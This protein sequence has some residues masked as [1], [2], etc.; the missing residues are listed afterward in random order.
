[1]KKILV[2]SLLCS[3]L[4]AMPCSHAQEQGRAREKTNQRL[5]AGDHHTNLIHELGLSEETA[6]KFRNAIANNKTQLAPLWEQMQSIRDEIE[7]QLRAN[8]PD[9]ATAMAAVDKMAQVQ[10]QI[11]AIRIK[12]NKLIASLLT[13]EQLAKFKELR[14]QMQANRQNRLEQH[15]HDG[16]AGPKRQEGQHDR[17]RDQNR[18]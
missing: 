10:K 5:S 14:N 6:A 12:N 2:P 7:V 9:E 8:V 18:R 15:R 16:I 1:M 17:P 13:P 11:I 3:L 4:L